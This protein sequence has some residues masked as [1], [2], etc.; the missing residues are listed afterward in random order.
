M[1]PAETKHKPEITR[2]F[3]SRKKD[4]SLS[5]SFA[6]AFGTEADA[7]AN[8]DGTVAAA[9]ADDGDD[10]DDAGGIVCYVQLIP[11]KQTLS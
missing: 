9:V 2:T 3:V 5:V 11:L 7:D 10:D 8:T 4:L 6:S 1:L